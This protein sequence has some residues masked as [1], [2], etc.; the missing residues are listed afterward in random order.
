MST[1][2]K[3]KA[4]TKINIKLPNKYCVIYYN[5]DKTPASFVE[6]SLIRIFKYDNKKAIM[7]TDL[8]SNNGSACVMN[9]LTK[10]IANHLTDLVLVD[11]QIRGFPLKVEAQQE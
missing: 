1:L 2:E 7:I 3:T 4:S 11:A 6:D 5:D 9:G 8:I 10:E